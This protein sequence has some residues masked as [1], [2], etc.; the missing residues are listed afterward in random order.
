MLSTSATFITQRLSL[1]RKRG[2]ID[3]RGIFK[4]IDRKL[5]EKNKEQNIKYKGRQHNISHRDLS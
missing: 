4:L 3:T 2:A 5:T 1:Q